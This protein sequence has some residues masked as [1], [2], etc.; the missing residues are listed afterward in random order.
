MYYRT[1]ADRP[2]N[3]AADAETQSH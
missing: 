3:L 2:A 1:T